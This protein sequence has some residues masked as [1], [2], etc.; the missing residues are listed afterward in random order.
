MKELQWFTPIP[1]PRVASAPLAIWSVVVGTA[2]GGLLFTRGHRLFA[3]LVWA[4]ALLLTLG[5]N[6]PTFR[7]PILRVAHWLGAVAGR[8]TTLAVLWPF[9]VLV[10]G[11]V[12]LTLAAAR[13]DLLGL[14]LHPEWPS[15]W[16]PAAPEQKRAKFYQRLFTVE[17][18]RQESHSLAWV[19]GILAFVMVLAGS[20]ELIL[21]AMGFGNPI[22]YQVDPRVGYYPAPN[23]DVHRYGGEIHINTFGMR[24]RD[25]TAAK[26]AGTFRILML[27]D[28]TLYG[29]SYIDQS[30]IYST[31]LEGLLDQNLSV[32]PNS[33]RQVE[34]LSMGVNAWGPQHELAYLKEFGLFEADLVMVMGPPGDAY[35]ERYGIAQ[36]PFYADGHRPQFAWQEF[37]DH[38]MWEHNLRKKGTILRSK[39][40][41][42]A[43]EV[44]ADGV[45][46]WLEMASLAQAQ[47]ARVDFEFLPNEEEVRKGRASESS[48]RVLDALLPELIRERVPN[49]FP[50]Q[51]FQ[52]NGRAAKLYHDGVHLNQSGHKT[53]ALYL[54]DRVLRLASAQ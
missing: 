12:R 39:A 14:R 19:I 24:S 6:S 2:S 30:Q 47:G 23:Q 43:G 29:G 7:T 34:V 33:P 37:W 50:V 51:L 10:F 5:L 48:Q 8:I 17:P 28:S 20:S 4:T 3:T 11:A 21:R 52:S 49:A 35:R 36:L 46:A 16:R 54:R 18:S 22:V 15:Y 42:Q 32:L 40:S 41:Q 45:A 38:M 13:V 25:V 9:Y 26:P 44:L 27:G 31:R 1:E 53:Y